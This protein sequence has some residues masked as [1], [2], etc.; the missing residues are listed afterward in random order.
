[1]EI[2]LRLKLRN[3]FIYI[4]HQRVKPLHDSEYRAGNITFLGI[5]QEI[6][7]THPQHI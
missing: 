7:Y 1:M 5:Y 3:L 6:G 2:T 4:R